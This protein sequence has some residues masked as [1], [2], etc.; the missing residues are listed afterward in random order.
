MART[1]VGLLITRS[2]RLLQPRGPAVER[3]RLGARAERISHDIAH[4]RGAA[5]A[6]KEQ[7]S[8]KREIELHSPQTR[9]APRESETELLSQRKTRKKKGQRSRLKNPTRGGQ[10]L[11]LRY[12]LLEQSLRGKKALQRD[13]RARDSEVASGFVDRAAAPASQFTDA[14]YCRGLEVPQ[15]PKAPES[16][17]C[18]MSGCA[19]CVYDLYEESLGTYNESL[20]A[21]RAKLA[22][23]DIT[24]A[25]CSANVRSGV[26]KK[27]P[28]LSA[29]EELERALNAKRS[30]EAQAQ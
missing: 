5:A 11:S 19:V 26:E 2:R 24:E 23:A 1:C 3:W 30:S 8:W 15:R 28:T 20:A 12:R 14:R 29:L 6:G 18:C 27:S 4:R 25:V 17:E 21:F 16:D 10:N 13:I 22:S 9:A 7:L